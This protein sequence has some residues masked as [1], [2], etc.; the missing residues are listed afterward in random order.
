MSVLHVG[1]S[2]PL[3]QRPGVAPDQVRGGGAGGSRQAA[4]RSCG[5]PARCVARCRRVVAD[6]LEALNT[7]ITCPVH[8]SVFLVQPSSCKAMC[9]KNGCLGSGSTS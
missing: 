5:W 8:C 9:S 7:T 6:V 3:R 2:A 4:C 1:G